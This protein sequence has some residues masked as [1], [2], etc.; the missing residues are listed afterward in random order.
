[1]K[2]VN[3]AWIL[4]VINLFLFHLYTYILLL[5]VWCLF[6]LIKYKWIMRDFI[7]LNQTHD[8]KE[9]N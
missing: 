8:I 9:L 3:E 4:F 6:N 2:V 1:M 7:K 5:V